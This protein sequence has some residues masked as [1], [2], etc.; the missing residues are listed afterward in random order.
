MLSTTFFQSLLLLVA[1]A[2][3]SS[4][5]PVWPHYSIDG[6]HLEV[7]NMRA[8]TSVN[9]GAVSN[10]ECLDRNK[11]IV[12]HDQ[13]VAELSICGGIAGSIQKCGGAPKSTTG[14]S[15]SAEF[16]LSAATSGA[17]INISKGRWEQCVRAAR[18]VCPTGSMKGTCTGG[19]SSGNVDFTLD[20]PL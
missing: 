14:R 1:G 8:S 9:P 4:A 7:L 11:N 15:G 16:K 6:E 20:S 2:S 3:L 19:A 12:F 18:A 5:S 10:V 17:T 13:N